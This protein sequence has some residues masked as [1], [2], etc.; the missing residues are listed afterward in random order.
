MRDILHQPR[1]MVRLVGHSG[2]GKTRLV[3]ALFDSRVGEH[4]LDSALAFYTNIANEPDPQP[5]AMASFL[6]AS[7][8]PGVLI[9]D[10][11]GA[12]L[13]QQLTQVC[14]VFE[15]NLS[16]ITVEYDIRDHQPEATDVFI[17][18]SA[19]PE[20]ITTLFSVGSRIYQR[21]M[22]EQLRS[23]LTEMPASQL[24]WLELFE[25][26]SRL[27]SSATMFYFNAFS[28]KKMILASLF[29]ALPKLV[30]WFIHSMSKI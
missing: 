10:N 16:V 3:Q 19:S 23:C 29:C 2:V 25:A 18:K 30:R 5:V 6:I 7:R 28:T 15:S 21:S 24:L 9:V 13:H 26:G 4:A 20:L 17:L 8:V 27:P 11:C 22:R 1:R 12:E 14:Q